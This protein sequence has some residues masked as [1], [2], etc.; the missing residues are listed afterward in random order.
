VLALALRFGHGMVVAALFG[1]AVAEQVI[2]PFGK[3]FFTHND[4]VTK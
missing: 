4:L 3:S 2:E 1:L